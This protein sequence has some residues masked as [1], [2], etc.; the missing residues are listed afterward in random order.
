MALRDHDA[1]LTRYSAGLPLACCANWLHLA[2]LSRGM[3]GKDFRQNA[4][5]HMEKPVKI[6]ENPP[7]RHTLRELLGFF[8]P[9]HYQVGL[10]L[11]QRICRD[12]LSRQQAAIIW[13][14]ASEAGP[15]GLIRRRQVDMTI[16]NWFSI[17]K[18]RVTQLIAELEKPPLSLVQQ[19]ANPDSGREK[20][21]GLTDAGREYH[22]MMVEAGLDYFAEIL[23]HIS[24]EELVNGMTFLDR[25]FG[26]PADTS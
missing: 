1:G 6:S 21:V 22:Q 14:I 4:W 18:S 26:P 11:E 3:R 5:L 16:N 2:R 23:S 12:H 17:R 7:T 19:V 20:L 10:E 9:I 24:E 8:Y 15:H 25:A 13:M